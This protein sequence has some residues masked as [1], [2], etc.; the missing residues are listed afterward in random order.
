MAKKFLARAAFVVTVLVTLGVV[1][2]AAMAFTVHR[3]LSRYQPQVGDVIVQ[4]IT[5]CGRLLRTVKGV[6]QSKWCH[7]GVV[8]HK[9]GQWMVCE[10]VGEGVRY[11]PLAFFLLRGDEIDFEVYRLK[12]DVQHHAQDLA[13]CCQTYVGRPYDIQYELDDEKIYCSELIYKA[14]RDATDGGEVSIAERFGDLNWQ[15]H[16]DDI[17]HYH[18][19]DDLPLDR[20]VVTPVSLTRSQQL[21]KIFELRAPISRSSRRAFALGCHV[22]GVSM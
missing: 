9:D 13:K 7:C 1:G 20:E 22:C 2:A 17:I 19:S 3:T 11:T 6:T 12:G 15:P 14:Y 10:A 4:S 5:P 21:A 8:D 16:K 18:G